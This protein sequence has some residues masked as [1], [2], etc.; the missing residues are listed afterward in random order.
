MDYEA[1]C[2]MHARGERLPSFPFDP[3]A[4]H[5]PRGIGDQ[6]ECPVCCE[7]YQGNCNLRIRHRPDLPDFC[8]FG[9]GGGW[10]VRPDPDGVLVWQGRCGKPLKQQTLAFAE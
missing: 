10:I 4:Q 6:G 9:C 1:L 2:V 5:F 3:H 7:P 8:H